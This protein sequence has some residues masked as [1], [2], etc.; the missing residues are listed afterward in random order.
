MAET[1]TQP[2]LERFDGEAAWRLL[3]LED[4]LRIGA[5]ALETA[6]TL[7]LMMRVDEDSLPELFGRVAMAAGTELERDLIAAVGDALPEDAFLASDERSP[8]I[9]SLLGGV[10]RACGCSQN[11]ACEEGCGWAAEDLCTACVGGGAAHAG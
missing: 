8:R 6:A 11:D 3:S 10:C 4:Q 7:H 2:A 1:A 5:I 9:P